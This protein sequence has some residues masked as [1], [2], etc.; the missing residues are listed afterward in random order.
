MRASAVRRRAAAA[1][2]L[3]VLLPFVVFLFLVAV[4]FCRVYHATQTLQNCAACG[5]QY[6]SR[7]ARGDSQTTSAAAARQAAVAEGAA[8][9]PPLRPEDVEVTQEA[10]VLVTV[11]VT[12]QFRMITDYP[13]LGGTI[14]IRRS[15]TAERVPKS[16][17]QPTSVLELIGLLP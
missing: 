5:A 1:A 8:L 11:T 3:A 2:E 4:D 13:G 17:D 12:Y 7:N 6:A 16:F 15:T 9:D 10:G 14:L